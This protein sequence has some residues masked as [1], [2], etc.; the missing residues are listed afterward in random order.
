[1]TIKNNDRLLRINTT[2]LGEEPSQS[3]H[4]NQY[5][6][7]PYFVLDALF[8]T[9][10]LSKTDG[11]VDYGCGKGRVMFY[12]HNRFNVPVTG[13]EMNDQ[14]YHKALTNKTHY[15]QKTKGKS[16]AIRISRCKAE[17]Y[18]VDEKENRFYFFNPFSIEI[19]MK[20]VNNIILSVEQLERDVEMILY[21]PIPEYVEYLETNTPF[22]F[23]RE[24]QIPQLYNINNDERFLIYRLGW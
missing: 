3:A 23:I 2:S 8:N 22:D 24:M 21:Y 14:L 4:Y 5:E 11:L 9:Y 15:L 20:V 16:P 7:T 18:N 17:E 6:A 1:M 13:I 10:E 12:V 19:F